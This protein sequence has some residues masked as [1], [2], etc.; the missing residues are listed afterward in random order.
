M[1]MP[2][3]P[4]F[5]ISLIPNEYYEKMVEEVGEGTYLKLNN[6]TKLLD[7][8]RQLYYFAKNNNVDVIGLKDDLEDLIT[9]NNN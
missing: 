3:H 2:L 8:N 1:I 6:V 5:A 7:L 9:A 4:K